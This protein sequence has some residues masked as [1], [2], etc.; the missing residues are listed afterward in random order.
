MLGALSGAVGAANGPQ[1]GSESRI[2]SSILPLNSV[3]IAGLT[4]VVDPQDS[5]CRLHRCAKLSANIALTNSHAAAVANE[6]L[7][8]PPASRCAAAS[9]GSARH[10]NRRWAAPPIQ[11]LAHWSSTPCPRSPATP[12]R[13]PRPPTPLPAHRAAATPNSGQRRNPLLRW[14]SRAYASVVAAA[15]VTVAERLPPRQPRPTRPALSTWR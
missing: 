7:S 6:G 14:Q 1:S 13:C 9:A 2:S 11:R 15:S 5:G 3:A 4:L 8:V 10:R 12:R